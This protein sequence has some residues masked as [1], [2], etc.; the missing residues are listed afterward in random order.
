MGELKPVSGSSGSLSWEGWYSYDKATDF[1]RVYGLEKWEPQG[2]HE[3]AA[4]AL[5]EPGPLLGSEVLDGRNIQ[6]VCGRYL[7]GYNANGE[8]RN[9]FRG[10]INYPPNHTYWGPHD[11]DPRFRHSRPDH[12]PV[13]PYAAEN[14]RAKEL[15]DAW[16]ADYERDLREREEADARARE[17][18]EKAWVLEHYG[19]N[20]DWIGT[21]G[22]I[23]DRVLREMKTKKR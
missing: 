16:N 10:P 23:R 13:E 8:E 2:T 6:S 3:G 12:K 20:A 7:R 9:P 1:I 5:V 15:R 19:P 21:P 4:V 17:A 22:Q 18:I 11:G 14:R